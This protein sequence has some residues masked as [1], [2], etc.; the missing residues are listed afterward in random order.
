MNKHPALITALFFVCA[1]AIADQK[2]NILIFLVDDLGYGDLGCTGST[3][4]ETP[5]LDRFAEEA[6]RFT[7]AYAPAA[8]CS[9]SRAAIMTGQYPARLHITTWIGGKKATEY[10]GLSLPKQKTFLAESAYTMGEYF[11]AQGYTTANIGKWH[12][13]GTIV[14]LQKHGF[15]HVIGYAP[16]AGPGASEAWFGP[17]PQIKDL[18]GPSDEYITDRLTQ[19][20][21][22]FIEERDGDPFFIMLQHYDVHGPL[23]APDAMVQK[24]V[25]R[26]RPKD[27]G[28]EN[29]TFLAM[30]ESMDASFGAIVNKLKALDLYDDTIIIFTSDNGGVQYFANNGGLRMGKKWLYEGGIRV[31]LLMRVPGYTEGGEVSR[32]PINGIDFF[33]TLVELTG[34]DPAKIE[35]DLDGESFAPEL[36]QV[37]GVKREALFWHSP[38]L[39]KGGGVIA[40]S[41]AVRMGPWKLI[42]YYGDT[43]V[44]ELY[45]VEN[46]KAEEKNLASQYPEL[47]D[48]IQ[49]MLEKHLDET[50]A[51]RVTLSTVIN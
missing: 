8:H 3:F 48:R 18:D 15:E 27:K 43:K 22:R 25:A 29:A 1:A 38:Q 34:G 33:P 32:L 26:R 28:I 2:P 4:A 11:Q 40:P 6:T 9:P 47:V 41:G 31:P 24:Y 10:K 39:G 7:D 5:H 14:P 37:A 17:Y 23:V 12:A 36:K 42:S 19:E 35:S 50:K 13:G 45:N 16:G 30:K 51:Q 46:D 20:T 44:P 21:I 49:R